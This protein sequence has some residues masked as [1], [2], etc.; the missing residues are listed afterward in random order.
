M[1]FLAF[2]GVMNYQLFYL[3]AQLGVPVAEAAGLVG[4]GIALQVVFLVV[5]SAVSGVVS[6]RLGCRRPFVVVAAAIGVAGLVLLAL[7]TNLPVWAVGMALIGVASGMYY[8]VDLA[9][10]ADVL[11][12]RDRSAAKNFGLFSIANQLPQTLAPALAPLFLAVSFGSVAAGA[13]NYT[14]LF[15]ACAL[16]AL[17]SAVTILPVRGVR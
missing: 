6:D 14:A 11:P 1:F 5:T 10:V 2:A 7:A 4:V 16:F 13:S 17:V 12:D 9:L 3:S 8:S 15:S